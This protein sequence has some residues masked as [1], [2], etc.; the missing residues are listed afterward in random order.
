MSKEIKILIVDDTPMN[1]AIITGFLKEHYE[2]EMAESGVQA[3]EI[4]ATHHFDLILLDVMMPEM[5]G[6][7]VCK[8][9]KANSD[10]QDIPVIFVTS[11]TSAEEQ[12]QGLEAGAE[13]YIPKPV[14][15]EVLLTKIQKT[16]DNK[17]L[18]QQQQNQITNAHSAVMTALEN[19]NELNTLS[20]YFSDV[21]LVNNYDNLMEHIINVLT[22]FGIKQ[23]LIKIKLEGEEDLYSSTTGHVK[24]MEIELIK[25]LEDKGNIYSYKTVTIFNYLNLN[26]LIYDLPMD[27]PDLF[28]RLKDHISMMLQG[29]I[30]IVQS[31]SSQKQFKQL[32]KTQQFQNEKLSELVN[33]IENVLEIIED[34]QHRYQETNKS[35][36]NN[37]FDKVQ[38]SFYHLGLTEAQEQ[39][40]LAMITDTD[41]EI[42]DLFDKNVE[43]ENKF[44]LLR[45]LI[46]M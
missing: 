35:I 13:D 24:P 17:Q 21:S 10:T 26:V 41:N 40:L 33:T 16:F 37:L 34:Q 23:A 27:K 43:L 18:I 4:L 6:Y 25:K 46:K 5:D 15:K 22:I 28:G 30:K 45:A 2:I 36:M 38:T 19:M 20:N 39:N 8:K 9:I 29:S 32:V 44:A 1:V 42:Q 31:I 7:E 3:L 12:L 14:N 11:L